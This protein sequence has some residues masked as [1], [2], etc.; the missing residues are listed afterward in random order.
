MGWQLQNV[1]VTDKETLEETLWV[2]ATN[3]VGTAFDGCVKPP[4]KWGDLRWA[5]EPMH[6]P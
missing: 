2:G 6:K 5:S 4:L 3:I 1:V